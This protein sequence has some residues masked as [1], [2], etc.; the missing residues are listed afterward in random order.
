MSPQG[1]MPK[2]NGDKHTWIR[3]TL[4]TRISYVCVRTRYAQQC[5]AQ[6][7]C[8]SFNWRPVT[9]PR[10]LR[11]YFFLKKCDTS[12]ITERLPWKR[13]AP[14]MCVFVYVCVFFTLHRYFYPSTSSTTGVRADSSSLERHPVQVMWST[15]LRHRYT[16][17]EWFLFVYFLC[18][19][20]ALQYHVIVLDTTGTRYVIHT[21]S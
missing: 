4:R 6:V 2:L 16:I 13:K 10:W 5:R 3:R 9:T 20:A 17:N 1:M 12:I 7:T 15:K 21:L 18:F 19:H 8:S 11:F 14:T